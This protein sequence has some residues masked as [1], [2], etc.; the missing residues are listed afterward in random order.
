MAKKK[1]KIYSR[2]IILILA[3]CFLYM[4]SIQMVTPLIAGFTGELGGSGTIMGLICGLFFYVSLVMRPVSGNMADKFSKF[5][6]AILGLTCMIIGPVGYFLAKS[7]VV[8]VICRVINGIG[9]AFCS[10]SL[11]T[12]ISLLMPK[13]HIGRGMGMFGMMNAIA[14]AVSPFISIH[15]YQ[16]FG[17]RVAF[18]AAACF[19]TI[20]LILILSVKN[21]Q[22]PKDEDAPA[23]DNRPKEKKKV[24]LVY[25]KIIY[26]AGI[27]LLFAIPQMANQGFLLKYAERRMLDLETSLYFTVYA[28]V[29]FVMRMF[30]KDLFD[31]VSFKK[32]LFIGCACTTC[33]MAC[34]TF[35]KGNVLL[36]AA[37]FFMSGSFGLMNSV[38]QSNAIKEAGPGKRGIANSTFYIGQDMGSAFGTTLAGVIY[39]NLPIEYF[40]PVL[41][42]TVPLALLIYLCHTIV[43]KSKA[44]KASF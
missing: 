24:M 38:C 43:V 10:V 17:Y 6:L 41:E 29:L 36:F 39:D 28:V 40:Y 20:S 14:M 34:F 12:W 18:I 35:M 4:G 42:L 1:E 25:P 37:A 27:M 22:D 9:Y 5:K 44:K 19:A 13:E 11:T 33:A 2:D 8:V 16:W 3:A 23:L 32:F 15:L 7:Y 31:T 26:I 30:I 21:K